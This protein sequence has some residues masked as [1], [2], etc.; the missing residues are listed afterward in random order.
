MILNRYL[1]G[2]NI[3]KNYYEHFIIIY[4]KNKQVYY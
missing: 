3:L 4:L 2:S 1:A